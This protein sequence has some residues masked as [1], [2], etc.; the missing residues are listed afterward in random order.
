[1]VHKQRTRVNDHASIVKK[2]FLFS[3][4]FLKCRAVLTVLILVSVSV[5][6]AGAYKWIVDLKAHPTPG[7]PWQ[8][9]LRTAP[10]PSCAHFRIAQKNNT[11]HPF[12]ILT[13]VICRRKIHGSQSGAIFCFVRSFSWAIWILMVPLR[14]I[15]IK[16]RVIPC[17][18]WFH[19]L[20]LRKFYEIPI[21]GENIWS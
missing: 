9:P 7:H 4:F 13:Y 1:M 18:K 11:L 21:E 10:R 15:N 16:I 5:A 3:F 6:Q 12:H 19:C 17:S 20:L 8:W 2:W 14:L